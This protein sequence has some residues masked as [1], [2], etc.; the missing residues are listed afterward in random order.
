MHRLL[1]ILLLLSSFPLPH[2]SF[3]VAD[4]SVTLPLGPYYRP[5]K[6]IPVHVTATLLE[7]SDSWLVV[8]ADNVTSNPTDISLGAG[9]T[10]I[11]L[12]QGRIDAVVPWLVLDGR[13]KRPKLFVEKS[14]DFAQGPEL[15]LLGE[16]ER[17][18]GWTTP[19]EAFARQ[20]LHGAPK[21]IPIAL[22]PAD[23]IKGHAAAWEMLDAIIL[24]ATSGTRLEQSQL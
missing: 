15:K 11:N 10:S 9:R 18:V 7:N 5:G 4:L 17:L 16:S 20:L 23:P 14:E 22:D 12:R 2:S 3:A 13:A 24:D 8:A 19:D 1:P 6:Y 21:I